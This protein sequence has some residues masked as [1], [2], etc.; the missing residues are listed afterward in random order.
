MNNN[1]YITDVIIHS[2]PQFKDNLSKSQL[3]LECGWIIICNGIFFR[4]KSVIHI[5]VSYKV[6]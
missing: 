3:K 4:I 1:I 2:C 6:Y 5:P